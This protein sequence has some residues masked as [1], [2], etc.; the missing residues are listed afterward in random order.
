MV[1]KA[2]EILFRA[3]SNGHLM[4]EPKGKSNAEKLFDAYKE[5][6]ETKLA[7]DGMKTKTGVNGI[8]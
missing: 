5:L 1:S 6:G 7:Y 8:K 2:E 3:S 4:T